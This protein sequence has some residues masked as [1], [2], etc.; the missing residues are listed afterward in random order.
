M[1]EERKELAV[2]SRMD[3]FCERLNADFE[4]V[5][6][7]PIDIPTLKEWIKK[8]ME[9]FLE[10][11]SSDDGS[12]V[13]VKFG[14]SPETCPRPFAYALFYQF[15]EDLSEKMGKMVGGCKKSEISKADSWMAL[16]YDEVYRIDWKHL[17]AFDTSYDVAKEFIDVAEMVVNH[18]RNSLAVLIEKIDEDEDG[19]KGFIRDLGH[20]RLDNDGMEALIASLLK[21]NDIEV[22]DEVINSNEV[23]KSD[24]PNAVIHLGRQIKIKLNKE[25]KENQAA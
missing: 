7:P 5:G 15:I 12:D 20:A 4:D 1:F 21:E 14:D 18:D 2:Y 10:A 9:N 16:K 23:S 22:I 3:N 17:Q 6:L 19:I 24:Y 11:P 13:A 8:Q 25:N